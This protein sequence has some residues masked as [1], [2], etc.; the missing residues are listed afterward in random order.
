MDKGRKMSEQK[1]E[2]P[3]RGKCL[4]EDL[5]SKIKMAQEEKEGQ[6]SVVGAQRVW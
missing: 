2:Y 1:R 4:L 3:H 5:K 6:P